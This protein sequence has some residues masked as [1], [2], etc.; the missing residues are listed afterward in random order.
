MPLM[1]YRKNKVGRLIPRLKRGGTSRR[2]SAAAIEANN[3]RIQ[4]QEQRQWELMKMGAERQWRQ[5]DRQAGHA[6]QRERWG[7][8]DERDRVQYER[9]T[10]RDEERYRQGELGREDAQA[11]AMAMQEQR[12]NQDARRRQAAGEVQRSSDMAT[13]ARANEDVFTEYESELRL[14][15]RALTPKG[16]RALGELRNKA[17][18][19]IENKGLTQYARQRA[20][21][22]VHAET[23]ALPARAMTPE[24]LTPDKPI[25]IPGTGKA[26]TTNPLSEKPMVVTDPAIVK[27]KQAEAL[28][29]REVKEI[30]PYEKEL[31]KA[32]EAEAKLDA[33]EA[34]LRSIINITALKDAG[35]G[36]P[37]GLGA[38]EGMYKP[39]LDNI[40]ARRK[41]L[42]ERGT[43]LAYK[44]QDTKDAHKIARLKQI[45]ASD[46]P[47]AEKARAF[48]KARGIQ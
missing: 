39:Q 6:F 30:Q 20:L 45:A 29:A 8:L 2:P 24:E 34:R 38:A 36:T 42:Q 22:T 19:I 10:E 11:H 17:Y 31:Q 16:Q 35:G 44:I 41:T 40:T 32:Q 14:R 7:Q 43:E 15:G 27:Q 5:E 4:L 21:Q 47:G 26:V 28:Q 18:R 25:V 9:A 33:E 23:D 46:E 12:L 48:L 37:I 13:M 1:E 3:R